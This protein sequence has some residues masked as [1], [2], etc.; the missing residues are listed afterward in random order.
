MI[1]MF[2]YNKA[3]LDASAINIVEGT[4][5]LARQAYEN[6]KAADY[7][8]KNSFICGAMANY[9]I[10]GTKFE[11]R[12]EGIEDEEK[13]IE[14]ARK[15]FE[16]ATVRN[17]PTVHANFAIILAQ[18]IN[19]INPEVS[20][21]IFTRFIAET[22]QIGYGDTATFQIESND[23]FAVKD[24]AEGIRR[25]VDQPMWDDEITVPTH[26]VSLSSH[27]DWYPFA[28]GRFDMG[29]FA[30]KIAKSFAAYIF[31]KAIKGMVAATAEFG[32][33]YQAAGVSVQNWGTLQQRV[34]AANG[35]MNV[36]AIG[37]PI[38]L[39]A[40][41]LGGNYQVMIGEEMNKVGYLDQYLNTPLVAIDNVLAAGAVNSTGALLIPD[42]VIY[43]IPVAGD[44]PV[45]IVFE[46]NQ[47]TVSDDPEKTSDER[48]GITVSLR[49][50][51][52]AVCG[53]K[54]GTINL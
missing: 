19:A 7:N 28:A 26:R 27:I 49:L 53:S 6:K 54:F 16:D 25:T 42:D 31:V 20:N 29:Y 38:A 30:V 5:E 51:V 11:A 43:M 18:V 24:Q 33:A 12:L 35:G 37:T 23:L 46:G 1:K 15:L 10:A 9:A 40:A 32:A 14:A 22:R 8:E 48:Y 2:S 47:T 41:N 21:D 13:K 45:K 39:A 50:G 3:G 4:L 36:I 34:K 17:N 44:K 52:S